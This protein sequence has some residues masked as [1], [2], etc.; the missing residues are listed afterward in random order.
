MLFSKFRHS[1]VNH[2]CT[3]MRSMSNGIIGG[4]FLS[5]FLAPGLVNAIDSLVKPIKREIAL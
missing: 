3:A 2:E 1:L 4:Q 5:F